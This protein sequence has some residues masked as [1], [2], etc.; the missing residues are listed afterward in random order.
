MDGK[1]WLNVWKGD[2]MR[3]RA[4]SVYTPRKHGWNVKRRDARRCGQKRGDTDDDGGG[5]DG[6]GVCWW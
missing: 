3:K 2:K 6:G 5:G 1:G 4:V